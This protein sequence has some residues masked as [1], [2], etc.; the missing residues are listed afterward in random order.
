MLERDP[1]LVKEIT[2]S[3]A[4]LKRAQDFVNNVQKR[5]L[6]EIS[7][8]DSAG[9]SF[10]TKWKV[11]VSP[12]FIISFFPKLTLY[13]PAGMKI[14]GR[15]EYANGQEKRNALSVYVRHT[16]RD[17]LRMF[18]TTPALYF[19]LMSIDWCLQVRSRRTRK[20]ICA[21]STTTKRKSSIDM[22]SS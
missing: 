6:S 1:S 5:A 9:P 7:G 4:D 22:E 15:A 18:A 19:S 12:A 2:R 14:P 10:F 16:L 17:R 20:L 3:F 8:L 11:G 21:I 13:V